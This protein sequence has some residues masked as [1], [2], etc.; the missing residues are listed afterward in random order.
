ML[1][2]DACVD[3]L[4]VDGSDVGC[5]FA[6]SASEGGFPKSHFW[7]VGTASCKTSNS[8]V[9]FRKHFSDFVDHDF[10]ATQFA[11]FIMNDADFHDVFFL[12]LSDFCGGIFYGIHKSFD[13][14][15]K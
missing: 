7:D 11:V 15:F 4:F 10:F 14:A 12:V 5:S 9:V 1:G 2:D 6:S 13:V 8:M 3:L